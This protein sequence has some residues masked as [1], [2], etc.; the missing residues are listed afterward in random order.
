M[1][2]TSG[3]NPLWFN[4]VYNHRLLHPPLRNEELKK[5][6]IQLAIEKMEEFLRMEGYETFSSK[7][8]ISLNTGHVV[9]TIGEEPPLQ[10]RRNNACLIL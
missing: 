6:A 3:K 4:N 10:V 2:I 5:R 8:S 7:F 9:I 1:I